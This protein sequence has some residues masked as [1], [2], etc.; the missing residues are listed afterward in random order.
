M[1]ACRF[2]GAW[3]GSVSKSPSAHGKIDCDAHQRDATRLC[4]KDPRLNARRSSGVS[5]VLSTR[6]AQT[7]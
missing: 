6:R 1:C 7:S 3:L 5:T 2:F 4:S